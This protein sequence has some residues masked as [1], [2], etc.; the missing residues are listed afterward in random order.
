MFFPRPVRAIIFDMDGLLFD[1]EALFFD[2][3]HAA[4]I[5]R[6]YDIPQTL[7]LKLLGHTREQNWVLMREH[8]GPGFPAEDFHALCRERFLQLTER[9]LRLKPGVVELL[10]C[11]DLLQLPRAIATSSLRTT[12]DRHLTAFGLADRFDA[13]I[14][15]GDYR[16]PKPAPAP[17]LAA[18]AA[19]RVEAKNC[20]ALEDSYN[21]V[22]SAAAA[23]MMTIMVPDLLQPTEEIDALALH[24]VRDL[25]EVQT[26]LNSHGRAERFSHRPNG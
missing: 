14:A 3:M 10:N 25:H 23:G 16:Q 5:E 6:G 4:G 18:A 12:V 19:L 17:Y 21:G 20:L 11:L 15:D 1:T 13:I 9:E 2:V 22:R 26:F 24:I 8:F 7:F